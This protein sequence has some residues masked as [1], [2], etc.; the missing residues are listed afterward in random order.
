[1]ITLTEVD[2]TGLRLPRFD[3][4]Y[5]YFAVALYAS[6]WKP[7]ARLLPPA[8]RP[9]LSGY[10]ELGT[11]MLG[12]VD[13]VRALNAEWTALNEAML[14]DR[15]GKVA[16]EA[17][18]TLWLKRLNPEIDPDFDRLYLCIAYDYGRLVRH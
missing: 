8:R 12:G 16:Y 6:P 13:E 3:L 14:S 2:R 11:K 4:P 5:G 9:D 7:T 17:S 10:L 18:L 15:I 1:M